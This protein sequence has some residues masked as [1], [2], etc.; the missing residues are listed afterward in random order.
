MED[1]TTSECIRTVAA[2]YDC[3]ILQLY[4]YDANVYGTMRTANGTPLEYQ[5][6]QHR[7]QLITGLRYF[8]ISLNSTSFKIKIITRNIMFL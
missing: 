8:C 6:M 5:F 3:K 2:T 1:N 7:R 4:E